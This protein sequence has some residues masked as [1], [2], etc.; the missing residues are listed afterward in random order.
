[1]YWNPALVP[2]TVLSTGY[3]ETNKKAATLVL[4]HCLQVMGTLLYSKKLKRNYLRIAKRSDFLI[5]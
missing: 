1:M 5:Q 4:A 3:I 2:G